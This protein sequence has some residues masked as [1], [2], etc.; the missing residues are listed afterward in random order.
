MLPFQPPLRPWAPGLPRHPAILHVPG[1]A[2]SGVRPAGR[3]L[4]PARSCS[5]HQERTLRL[6]L[7]AG[8][9]RPCGSSCDDQG[10]QVHGV[11]STPS[12]PG[13]PAAVADAPLCPQSPPG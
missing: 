11:R 7:A 3:G 9:V 12:C 6:M 8:E 10:L 2:G 4:L 1:A 13:R 5:P